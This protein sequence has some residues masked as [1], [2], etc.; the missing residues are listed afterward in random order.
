M[1]RSSTLPLLVIARL[2]KALVVTILFMLTLGPSGTPYGVLVHGKKFRFPKSQ[3][4]SG[5]SGS[6]S[7]VDMTPPTT[8]KSQESRR[9]RF[10][11]GSDGLR[12]RDGILFRSGT[13]KVVEKKWAE[14]MTVFST[15]WE[16]LFKHIFLYKPPVGIVTFV[17]FT[18]LI[19]TGRLFR[20]DTTKESEKALRRASDKKGDSHKHH[21]GR[22]YILDR[23]DTEYQSFGGVERVRRRLCWAALVKV[24]END[25]ESDDHDLNRLFS[26]IPPTC[27]DS[28][29]RNLITSII[30]VLKM[31]YA[32]GSSQSLF[33]GNMVESIAY[34]ERCLVIARSQAQMEGKGGGSSSKATAPVTV[35]LLD[36]LDEGDSDT[37]S[38][39]TKTSDP[40]TNN[41]TTT[42][43]SHKD[44]TDLDRVVTV[45][46]LTAEIRMLDG[47]LRILR[48]RLLRLSFRLSR[49][50]KHWRRRLNQSRQRSK[51]FS[52]LRW[53]QLDSTE[54]DRLRLAFAKSAYTS[55]VSRLGKVIEIIMDRP[56]GLDDSK[57][58]EAVRHT[59]KLE[60]KMNKLDL[61]NGNMGS[62]V[63]VEHSGSSSGR[64][65][66]DDW[67]LP[68]MGKFSFR[69]NTDG[70]GK[71]RIYSY[72][73]SMTVGGEGALKVLVQDNE[74]ITKEWIDEAREWTYNARR[75]LYEVVKDSI[76][77][78]MQPTQH[79]EEQL[80]SIE[81]WTVGEFDTTS[82]NNGNNG[83]L[84]EIHNQWNTIYE[85]IRDIHNYSRL[86]EGQKLR[87]KDTNLY[88]WFRQW[89][90][91]G[92]PSAF[93]NIFLARL[94]NR[95][96]EKNWAT[97]KA[98]WRETF[99]IS[100]DIMKQRFYDPIKD[101]VDDVMNHEKNS[102]LTGFAVDVEETSLDNM[103]RDL[104]FGDGTAQSRPEA[105]ER[106]TRQYESD[107]KT[108][109]FRHAMGGRLVRLILI[110][111]QQLKV[112]LL[113]AAESI[114]VL[115]QANRI[116]LQLLAIIPGVLALVIGTRIFLRLWFRFRAKSIRSI[117]SVYS[118][119]T[120]Y[121]NELE[122]ILLV[123]NPVTPSNGK[124][125]KGDGK[126][127]TPSSYR[128][129]QRQ[130]GLDSN[131]PSP[132][133]LSLTHHELGE[134][135]LILHNYLVL[136]DYSC[137]VPFPQWQC[138]V[139]HQSMQEFLGSNG[140]F[141]R[142]PGGVDR[143][144]ALIGQVK[145]KHRELA[146]Y[147]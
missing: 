4:D 98:V 136:L 90:L 105:L 49:T 142:L 51:K 116:N 5:S 126:N 147:L 143:Q 68:A 102:L 18:R 86:G 117:S 127:K 25:D 80:A 96:L 122:Y 94:A 59:V 52:L 104:D 145:E 48:D 31:T 118:E 138:E 103:L 101:L 41:L 36:E 28:I 132:S 100:T 140:S 10:N 65:K 93:L 14:L 20:L 46:A 97:V 11:P 60:N 29:S 35:S 141:H 95:W 79:E 82:T 16:V 113:N 39:P 50:E 26:G 22:S 38:P 55:E 54:G 23:D 106:A 42:L 71:F 62:E 124:G 119:M 139:V 75:V 128:N 63:P 109:L 67:S 125:R 34:M 9:R 21:R 13:L 115:L 61:P 64:S 135:S 40:N 146:G 129:K 3:K 56:L 123:A 121:L 2:L 70:R 53:F 131:T 84:D 76:I 134:F 91:L 66:S 45:A 57:L 87:L 32:P 107:M 12:H 83:D 112:G 114:D 72:E 78:S 111:V 99:D 43:A 81:S 74:G 130:R 19:V 85:L 7:H 8:K 47:L 120:E 108:G 6:G 58:A 24:L 27:P 133:Y 44:V 69:Y 37:D 77:E 144:I 89:D 88:I 1:S 110:Q 92:L 15:I 137:P 30:N 33:F 73:E 17:T